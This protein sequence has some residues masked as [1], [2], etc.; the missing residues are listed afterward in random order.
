MSKRRASAA[1]VRARI[2]RDFLRGMSIFAIAEGLARDGI[3]SP[4]AH[5]PGRNGHPNTKAWSK[6]AIR[7]ILTNARYTGRQVWNKQHKTKTL[8]LGS[9]APSPPQP[10]HN[11]GRHG[12]CSDR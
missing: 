4:S 8:I 5:D 6:S 7:V 1:A 2:Y 10:A 3:P 9:P 11:A 12:C